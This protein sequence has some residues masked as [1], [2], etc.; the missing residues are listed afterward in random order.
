M[1]LFHFDTISVSIAATPE[2]VW[3][4]VSDLNNW[5]QFSDFGK[6]LEQVSGA[7]WVAHTSQGDVRVI[8][9][10]DQAHLL[11]DH[12]CIIASGEEQFIPYRVVPNGT[13][14]ELI[15]TNQQ[16]ATVSDEEYHE[17]LRWMREELENIKM[18]ME[19]KS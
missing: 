9:Q 11:L 2:Q 17:Q 7:E 10:F 18:I 3:Q 12:R 19:V 13:G 1:N 16:T 14:A 4:F 15:M 8:P 6:Q 5:R